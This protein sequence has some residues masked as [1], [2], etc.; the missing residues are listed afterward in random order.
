MKYCRKAKAA[1]YYKFVTWSAEDKVFIG[2]CP[3]LFDGAV[4]GSDEVTVYKELVDACE[5]WILLLDKD[6]TP[7]PATCQKKFSGKFVVRLDPVL[8]QLTA[9]RAQAEGES[10][11]DFVVHKLA[12]A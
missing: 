11:N 2:R 8:H 7:L 12:K 6:G 10:L 9:A 4:H 5:E 1:Q 3:A